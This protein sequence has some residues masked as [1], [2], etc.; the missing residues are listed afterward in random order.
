M[1]RSRGSARKAG[2]AFETLVAGYLAAHVD[3]RV[4]RRTR[5]GAKD[6]GDISGLRHMGERI[7]VEV[8]NCARLDL[9][10]WLAEAEVERR[11]DD[12]VAGVVV[13]KHHGKGRP[14]EQLVTM[15]LADFVAVL[16][17]ARPEDSGDQGGYW[18]PSSLTTTS[19]ERNRRRPGTQL[20]EGPG[21]A[22]GRP[23]TPG[24]TICGG[25]EGRSR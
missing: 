13:H 12:A 4:E 17:A 16:T 8:K 25:G 18:L 24:A 23:A 10:G 11:N 7:V 19:P 21:E 5:S 22:S 15:T 1:S 2:T 20:P 14:A 6:R 9:A 3:D